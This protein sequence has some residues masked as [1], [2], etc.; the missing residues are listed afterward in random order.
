ME[1]TESHQSANIQRLSPEVKQRAVE[2]ARPAAETLMDRATSHRTQSV[3]NGSDHG[4]NREAMMHTQGAP[5]KT[6]ESLSP[7]DSHKGQ[8]QTQQKQMQRS[9]GMER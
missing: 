2:A 6:Q 3:G 7:T 9:R 5:G 8:S 1:R 4:D